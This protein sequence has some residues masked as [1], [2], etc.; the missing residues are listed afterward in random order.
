MEKPMDD[1]YELFIGGEWV[2][3]KKGKTY[4]TFSP[5]NGELLAECVDASKE[6][7]D[8]AVQAAWKAFATWKKTS[9]QERCAIL[10]KI[11][12]IVEAN[13]PKL[14]MIDTLEMGK[15]IRETTYVDIP[16]N[17]ETFRYFG[18]AIRVDE[19]RAVMLDEDTL[20]IIL[21]EP[22]GVVAAITPWNFPFGL[23]TWKIATALAAGC[24][25][26]L[27]SS[28]ETSLSMLEF[29]KMISAVV[30]PG[31]INL[32]TGKG[33]TTG[34]YLIDHPDIRKLA[35]TGSTEI[36]YC[37]AAAASK[38]LAPATLE[39]GGKSANIYFSDINWE[40]AIDGV[41]LGILFNQGQCCSAGSRVFVH[42]DIYD[43]FLAD[44]VTAFNKVKVGDPLNM[45]TQ[46]GALVNETQLKK[47]LNY[48]EIGKKEGARVACGGYRVTDGDLAKGCFMRP[49]I[50]ADVTN[51]MRVAREEIFG[52]VA[53]F[54]KFKTE[55]EVIAMA[56]D[57]DFGLGG[58]VWTKDINRAIRVCRGIETGRMW[59]NCYHAF[60]VHA[61]WGGVKK[62]GIG[63]ENHLMALDAYREVK[64][65]LISLSESKSGFYL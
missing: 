31:V 47:V 6:D 49:T 28:S 5:I 4:Q 45:E 42:E 8:R 58:A 34:Q 9:A 15:P 30:P 21:K 36:G 23:T 35:F 11:A 41:H 39:L 56:N 50:L 33:S 2:K 1:K 38:K 7:V 32:V 29:M 14:A 10:Y 27:K 19:G 61:P 44:C 52:P 62:T 3:G 13:V 18:S 57:S 17:A 54:I 65:I 59:V 63:R 24:T 20:S 12:D 40:K 60:P 53:C 48:V 26:V 43:K 16:I 55:E 64:S 51:N 25:M 37:I 22:I 46:M